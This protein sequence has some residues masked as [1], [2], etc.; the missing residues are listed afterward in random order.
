MA[1]KKIAIIGLGQMGS[2]L[3]FPAI[4]NGNEVRLVGT[5]HDAQAVKESIET[6]KHPRLDTPFPEGGK[7]YYC[8]QWEEAVSGVDFVIGAVS[9]YGVDW[10]L[11]EILAHLSPTIPVISATKGLYDLE[12]GSLISYPE[13]WERGLKEM[14]IRRSIS[15][16][17]G[18]CTAYELMHHDQTEVAFCGRNAT[19]LRMMRKALQ[20]S[21]F[22]ISLTRDVLGLESAVA[23]KNVY[24]LAVSMAIGT[25]HSKDGD[26]RSDLHFNSQAGVFYQASREMLRILQIQRADTDS[27]MMGIG[28]LY[29]TVSG[30]RTRKLGMCLGEGKTLDEAL[31]I[32]DGTTLESLVIIKRVMAAV[33]RMAQR[34]MLDT[35]DFPLLRHVYDVVENGADP[36]G[37]PWD[38]FIFENV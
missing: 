24:A 7:F 26:T 27:V 2:A 23:L 12:D 38:K 19:L 14:G 32:L 30:G 37:I 29:V 15:A 5:P 1:A 28:D 20:T 17:G 11:N 33:E 6:G 34:G 21:Y 36:D 22:H 16:I 4:E 10:F 3:A 9:S 35:A 31:K 8:D 18:P 25:S 13:Y